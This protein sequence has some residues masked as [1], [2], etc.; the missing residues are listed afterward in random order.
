MFRAVQVRKG[1]THRSTLTWKLLKL[2]VYSDAAR[3]S[4]I[5]STVAMQTNQGAAVS[6]AINDLVDNDDSRPPKSEPSA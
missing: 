6:L 5:S 4:T 3:S 1:M 2:T